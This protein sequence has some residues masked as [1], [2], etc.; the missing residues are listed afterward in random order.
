MKKYVKPVCKVRPV[1][2]ARMMATSP[3]SMGFGSSATPEAEGDIKDRDAYDDYNNYD[4][5][6]LW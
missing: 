1:R 4:N 5:E 3:L 6:S 2:T